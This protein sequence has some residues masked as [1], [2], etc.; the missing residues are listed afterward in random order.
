[1]PNQEKIARVAELT[2]RIERSSALLLT[3]YRGLSVS[4][5]TELR[6]SL[7]E[8]G[9]RFAVVK[10]TLMQRAVSEAGI[11]QLKEMLI[12][13]SAVAFVEGDPVAAA[14]RMQAVA[15]QFPALVVKGGWMDGQVLSADEARGLADL[16]S[17]EVMLSK[18]AGLM[19]G[20]MS[21]AAALFQ[22]A[23]SRFA[24]LLVA[25][26]ETLPSG[27]GEGHAAGESP[28]AED[29]PSADA[30]DAPTAADESATPTDQATEVAAE[31]E[32]DDDA[33]PARDEEE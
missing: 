27:D 23:Q 16:E 13:P 15:K 4:E 29:A 21:R 12:G 31:S 30:G 3:E 20:E 24:S 11:E 32:A 8:S 14:K 1:M 5:I 26:R 19:K 33:S 25:Y 7:R 6:R 10:N 17:R 2:A 22:A 9:T 28:A 18:I